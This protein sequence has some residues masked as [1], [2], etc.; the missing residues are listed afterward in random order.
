MLSIILISSNLLFGQ[1]DWTVYT[2]ANSGICSDTVTSI[3]VENNGDMWFGTVRGVSRFDGSKW[4][5]YTSS[6]SPFSEY[7]EIRSIKKLNEDFYFGTLSGLIKYNG[8]N[9]TSVSGFSGYMITCMDTDDVG[10][11]WVGTNQ[12]G[13]FKYNGTNIVV[14]DTSKA[15]PAETVNDLKVDQNGNIWVAMADYNY[16]IAGIAKYDGFNWEFFTSNNAYSIAEDK[17]GNLWF[18]ADSLV[19]KKYDGVNWYKYYLSN[20]PNE[21]YISS[22]SIDINE[23]IWAGLGFSYGDKGLIE[24]DGNNKITKYT[25][26]EGFP[27][28]LAVNDM[29]ADRNNNIWTGSWG[30]GLIELNNEPVFNIVQGIDSVRSLREIKLQWDY[31]FQNEVKIEYCIYGNWWMIVAD[32]VSAQNK[33][34]KWRVPI[35]SPPNTDCKIRI[36]DENDPS[37]YIESPSFTIYPKVETPYFTPNGGTK[38]NGLYVPSRTTKAAIFLIRQ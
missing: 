17:K 37:T 38:Y 20:Q 15:F 34:Y 7:N 32:S 22:L 29:L 12:Q 16:R 28:S 36:S 31:Q 21:N 1:S 3:F 35:V 5:N 26:T 11:L 6:N 9:W 27:G 30:G 24:F 23:N 14:Y 13:V 33:Y 2:T 18:G 10:N 19:L 25:E 4:T 8:N